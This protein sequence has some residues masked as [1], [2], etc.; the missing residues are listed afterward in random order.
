[1]KLF[2]KVNSSENSVFLKER[3]RPKPLKNTTKSSFSVKLQIYR[4]RSSL[5]QALYKIVVIKNLF[6]SHTETLV[7]ELLYKKVQG[8]QSATLLKKRHGI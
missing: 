4:L 6:K 3:L 2:V 1:M 5:L 8:L 7:P